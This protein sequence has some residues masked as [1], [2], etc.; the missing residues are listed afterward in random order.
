[1]REAITAYCIL[2]EAGGQ[3]RLSTLFARL[4]EK[5][6][7]D[8]DTALRAI[9]VLFEEGEVA[10]NTTGMPVVYEK[11]KLP[12]SAQELEGLA[13]LLASAFDFYLADCDSTLLK[14]HQLEEFLVPL[15]D[16]HRHFPALQHLLAE[17]GYSIS[18]HPDGFWVEKKLC[19]ST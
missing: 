15:H 2:R 12:L 19:K 11:R 4:R 1:M 5:T 9:E 14:P 3:M 18:K 13:A 17:H 10:M 16:V 7:C 8:Y 6:G